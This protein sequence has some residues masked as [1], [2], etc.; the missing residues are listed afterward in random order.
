MSKLSG[1]LVE[2]IALAKSD[3]LER[4]HK[5]LDD[6]KVLL[7]RALLKIQ[8][9]DRGFARADAKLARIKAEGGE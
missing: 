9:R 2:A 8:E 1:K 3:Y 6:A 5:A 7:E 4:K